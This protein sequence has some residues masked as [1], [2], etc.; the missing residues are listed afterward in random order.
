[1]LLGRPSAKL[2]SVISRVVGLANLRWDTEPVV[3]VLRCSRRGRRPVPS[4][5]DVIASY[6][7]LRDSAPYSAG[8]KRYD[9]DYTRSDG[10]V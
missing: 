10:R 8:S 4:Q 9:A 2:L 3:P 6:P 7:R 5:S 1:L